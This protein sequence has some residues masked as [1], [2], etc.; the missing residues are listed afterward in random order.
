M[1]IFTKAGLIEAL[2]RSIRT[3]AQ[4]LSGTLLVFTGFMS[5]DWRASLAAAGFAA[6]ISFL[7]CVAGDVSPDMRRRAP[8]SG[9]A[10]SPAV[11][12]G[13]LQR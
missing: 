11:D 3:F 6:A 9:L 13:S 4:T 12:E 8:R 2:K 10:H 7:Q 5:V 1:D